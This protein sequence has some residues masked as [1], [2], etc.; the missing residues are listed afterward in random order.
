VTS[1]DRL[2]EVR[3]LLDAAPQQGSALPTLRSTPAPPPSSGLGTAP[4]QAGTAA[5][6]PPLALAPSSAVGWAAGLLAVAGII[7]LVLLPG[8]L[9]EARGIGLYFC[10]VGGAQVVWSIL[11]LLRPT[12]A[13]AWVG[14]TALA[15]QPLAVYA[16]TRVVRQPF[17]DHAEG[18][19][20]IGILTGLLEAAAL[21]PLALHLARTRAAG[22]T[23]ARGVAVPVAIAIAAGLLF[24]GALYGLGLAAEE[25]VPW[26]DEPEAPHAHEA[27]TATAL[28]GAAAEPAADGHSH[29]H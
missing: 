5:A 7:H 16:L 23:V 24:G 29:S 27:A 28:D 1:P 3:R 2:D 9:G 10:A 25:L 4:V 18:V 14:L 12:R 6:P 11:Y 22:Q 15:V 13:T 19:D 20:L 26:L 21:V 17:G 8:H